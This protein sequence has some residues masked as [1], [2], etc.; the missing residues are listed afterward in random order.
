LHYKP[1]LQTCTTN[2]HYKIVTNLQEKPTLDRLRGG[3]VACSGFL[4]DQHPGRQTFLWPATLK[5][6]W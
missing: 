1:A 3:I 5:F 6:D 4:A 2:L